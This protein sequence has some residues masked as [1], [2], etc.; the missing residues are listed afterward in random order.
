MQFKDTVLI[1]DMRE[2]SDKQI[3]EV[4]S[5]CNK[6]TNLF[7]ELADNEENRFWDIKAASHMICNIRVESSMLVGDVTVLNTSCGKTLIELCKHIYIE[8]Y[9]RPCMY[10]GIIRTFHIILKSETLKIAD[11]RD[12]QKHTKQGRD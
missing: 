1:R 5:R 3:G 7:G 12:K 11:D 9:I 6:Y 4:I 2:Y 10:D 8:D